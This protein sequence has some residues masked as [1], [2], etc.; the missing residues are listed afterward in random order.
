MTINR[1]GVQ[2]SDPI[3]KSIYS[4]PFGKN[5]LHDIHMRFRVKG[6]WTLLSTNSAIKIN[7]ANKD[8]RLSTLMFK[9][10][11]IRVTVHRSNTVSVIVGCSYA[12]IA[13]DTSGIIRLSNVLTRIEERLCRLIDSCSNGCNSYDPLTKESNVSGSSFERELAV[14]EHSSWIVT[15]WHFGVDSVT[16]YTGEKFSGTW[17]IGQN[18]LLRAYSKDMREQGRKIRLERQEYPNKDF[19]D[20]IEEKFHNQHVRATSLTSLE[21]D[22]SGDPR[23]GIKIGSKQLLSQS[24]STTTTN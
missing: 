20:A 1:L 9:D 19:A 12:P 22:C 5:A 3:T 4:L 17:E 2:A 15:M 23:V 11:E 7:P 10:L 18:A 13:V 14:P 24:E 6:I 16:E 8:L 21:W